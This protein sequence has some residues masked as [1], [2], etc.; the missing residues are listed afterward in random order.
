ML[1]RVADSIYWMS[2]Y[3]ERAEN[4]A[5]FIDV[6]LNLML[7]LPIGIAQQ[8]QPLIDITGD[9]EEFAERY[10]AATQQNVI[11]FLTFDTENVNSVISCFRAAR[12][13]ARSVREVISSEMWQQI[14]EASLMVNAAAPAGGYS[15]D[16]QELF[17]SVKLAS[18]LF[19]GITDATMTHGE[20]W[21]FCQLGRVLERADKTSRIVDVKYFL[22]LP[23][24]QDVGTT[25]DDIQWTAVLRSASAF[26][27]YRKSHGR[28]APRKIIEFLLLDRQFPR[29][30]HY[31][32]NAARESVHAISG[33]PAGMFRTAVEQLFGSLCSELAYA[34]IDE[35]IQ[36]GLHEYLDLLQ[37]RLNQVGAEIHETFF[38]RNLAPPT[39]RAVARQRSATMSPSFD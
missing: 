33:T 30:I 11:Q 24:I 38:A 21:H 8:W 28:I 29:A 27:M 2:R 19:A 3:I 34:E 26:E 12:E 18:H 15:T 36:N 22:L 9:T 1:A 4:V 10:G 25:V 23:T 37:S 5:R 39:R 6:N 35:I 14:N 17:A 32:V 13:N 16:P 31:C 20:G 7:D